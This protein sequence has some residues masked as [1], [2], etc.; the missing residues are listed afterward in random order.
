[1][2]TFADPR[3]CVSSVLIACPSWVS[4]ASFRLCADNFRFTPMS[5][6]FQRPSACLKSANRRHR[7]LVS[8]RHDHSRQYSNFDTSEL[9]CSDCT[10]RSSDLRPIVNPSIGKL[11]CGS[12]QRKDIVAYVTALTEF[13]GNHLASGLDRIEPG[14]FVGL[15]LKCRRGDKV[16]IVRF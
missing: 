12:F 15:R 6:H 2:R 4:N 16:A 1:M 13:E 10:R 5:R 8:S 9:Q 14:V 7:D 3:L 11:R